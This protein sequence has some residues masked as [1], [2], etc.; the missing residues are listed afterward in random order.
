MFVFFGGKDGHRK[1][2]KAR[3]INSC[4]S[5]IR[6][7][8]LPENMK[9]KFGNA[10]SNIEQFENMFFGEGSVSTNPDGQCLEILERVGEG[11]IMT[12]IVWWVQNNG[13]SLSF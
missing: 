5:W 6:D 13:C 9:R 12:I 3:L 4:R 2:M 11:I 10:K 7:Q 8:Y 1:V